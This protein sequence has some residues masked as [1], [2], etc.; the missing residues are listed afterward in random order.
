MVLKLDTRMSCCHVEAECQSVLFMFCVIIPFM[1]S[2]ARQLECM[3]MGFA[4]EIH[5]FP[6]WN[7][8]NRRQI[9]FNLYVVIYM[10]VN[11]KSC[12]LSGAILMVILVHLCLALHGTQSEDRGG[13]KME[14][15]PYPIGI[16]GRT[17]YRTLSPQRTPLQTG[18]KWYSHLWEVSSPKLVVP[19]WKETKTKPVIRT[20]NWRTPFQGDP[21]DKCFSRGLEA[22]VHH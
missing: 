21:Y 6:I 18:T 8:G 22:L 12:K 19:K 1:F 15:D 3:F 20:L 9:L 2:N 13:H 10:K 7:L 4:E 11:E 14:I 17:T 5:I 16:G